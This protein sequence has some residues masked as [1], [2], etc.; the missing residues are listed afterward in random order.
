MVY[1]FI[2]VNGVLGTGR[3][4]A[5]EGAARSSSRGQDESGKPRGEIRLPLPSL[6]LSC[7]RNRAN[8]FIP[9]CF[10]PYIFLEQEINTKMESSL[11]LTWQ[12]L[13][14]GPARHPLKSKEKK[15]FQQ[16]PRALARGLGEPLQI[17]EDC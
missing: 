3:A 14:E 8:D 15:R 5:E 16:L 1:S 4:V 7:I 17:S 12:R 13:S 9:R 11:P 10:Q 2:T 6:S